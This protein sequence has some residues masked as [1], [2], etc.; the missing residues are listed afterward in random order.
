MAINKVFM[1]PRKAN[2][3]PPALMTPQMIAKMPMTFAAEEGGWS[4]MSWPGAIS[5]VP[6]RK[7]PSDIGTKPP[8]T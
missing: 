8:A 7:V 6:E 3:E 2:K 4:M 5:V 1:G